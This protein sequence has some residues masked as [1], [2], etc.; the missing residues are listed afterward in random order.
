[1][2]WLKH[3]STKLNIF[4]GWTDKLV[5]SIR[6]RFFNYKYLVVCCRPGVFT[7]M[8]SLQKTL[9]KDQIIFNGSWRLPLV[10]TN[11]IERAALIFKCHCDTPYQYHVS[12]LSYSPTFR[13]NLKIKFQQSAISWYLP[14]NI[15]QA[16]F[17]DFDPFSRIETPNSSQT[18]YDKKLVSL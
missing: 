7:W 2:T 4:L 18:F 8:N 13:G 15:C 1:M 6:I 14:L 11:I 17:T 16:I 9:W 5:T 3:N 10:S 12:T